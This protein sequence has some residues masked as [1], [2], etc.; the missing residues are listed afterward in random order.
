VPPLIAAIVT[1]Y[2]KNVFYGA[3]LALRAGL[4]Q[5]GMVFFLCNPALIPQ[6]GARLG[7]VPGY[8]LSS[9]PGLKRREV[10]CVAIGGVWMVSGA[11]AAMVPALSRSLI[12][13]RL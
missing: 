9:L 12:F 11:V 4:R 7:N 8:Y 5:S 10:R 2:L 3:P 13:L 6:R 1:I